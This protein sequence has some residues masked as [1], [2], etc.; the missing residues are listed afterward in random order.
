MNEL[1]FLEDIKSKKNYNYIYKTYKDML[2]SYLQTTKYIHDTLLKQLKDSTSKT[3]NTIKYMFINIVADY[4]QT[5]VGTNG[6]F[7]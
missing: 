4:L 7:E 1:Q 3:D 6:G 2:W 5:I